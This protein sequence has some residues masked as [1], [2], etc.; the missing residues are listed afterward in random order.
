MIRKLKQLTLRKIGGNYMLVKVVNNEVNMTNVYSMNA[1]AAW[2]W[3][4]IDKPYEDIGKI[5][6]QMCMVYDVDHTTAIA[7]IEMQLKQWR[8]LG[9]IE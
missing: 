9:L 5:A 2:I 1:T 3:R 7:D 6:E 4:N 8:E